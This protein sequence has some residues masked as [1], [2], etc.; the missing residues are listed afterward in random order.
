MKR[1][2]Y[3]KSACNKFKKQP[4]LIVSV[5]ADVNKAAKMVLE[6]V[7]KEKAQLLMPA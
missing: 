2:I 4:K 6:I 3:Y 5:L 1:N 7:N